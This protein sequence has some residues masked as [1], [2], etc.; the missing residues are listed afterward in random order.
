MK[1]SL[2]WLA[3]LLWTSVGCADTGGGQV[4]F[5]LQA[6]GATAN[7]FEVGAWTLRLSE[8]RLV[9]GPLWLCAAQG[10]QASCETARAEFLDAAVVDL[11]DPQT[12]AL[13]TMTGS[14]G[15]VGTYWFDYGV[16]SLLGQDEPLVLPA[17]AQTGG[18]VFIA[19]V[20][21]SADAQVAF[22]ATVT[23]S[24]S[25]NGVENGVPVV[26]R[27]S[28]EIRHVLDANTRSLLLRFDAAQIVQGIDFD[29]LAGQD[30]V[31]I[32]EPPTPETA[33]AV[34]ALRVALQGAAVPAFDWKEEE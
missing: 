29:A 9:F 5:D 25:A 6:E 4:A 34:S 32:T 2:T 12:Q 22:E 11:L 16:V 10:E 19:G 33:Q 17:A 26:R 27:A 30:V 7:E 20:A 18:S 15:F 24:Q 28:E 21:Q 8:A 1:V 23:L 13:G 3:F 31:S 14:E